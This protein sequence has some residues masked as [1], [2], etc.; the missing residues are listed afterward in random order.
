MTTL[1]H[2]NSQL[3][4]NHVP[5]VW[6]DFATKHFPTLLPKHRFL[7][8]SEIVEYVDSE[9][10]LDN[11]VNTSISKSKKLRHNNELMLFFK[12]SC[13][14][15]PQFK[16][17]YQNFLVL[18]KKEKSNMSCLQWWYTIMWIKLI[19]DMIVF[20]LNMGLEE[21]F[22]MNMSITEFVHSKEG[23]HWLTGCRWVVARDYLIENYAEDFKNINDEHSNNKVLCCARF[24]IFDIFERSLWNPNDKSY[25]YGAYGLPS[26]LLAYNVCTCNDDDYE[27]VK[28]EEVVI[29]SKQLNE[30][31]TNDN[32][33]LDDTIPMEEPV[34]I[35]N[36]QE[37][38]QTI[39]KKPKRKKLASKKIVKPVMPSS[40]SEQDD[41]END[42]TSNK[43]LKN[44]HKY[45][46]V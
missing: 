11:I 18:N 27:E 12:K 42:Q 23:V 40:D 10:A 20:S 22:I 32:I 44:N 21:D 41:E 8:W 46:I 3:K 38:E 36:K 37:E 5:K 35:N 4:T 17:I 1:P 28:D 45:R 33:D 26:D 2:F 39:E 30:L 34:N 24:D 19:N 16:S 9:T 13:K 6:D 14:L 7:K 15:N 43:R 29:G 31:D 25:Y